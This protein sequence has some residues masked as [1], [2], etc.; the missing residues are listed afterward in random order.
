MSK[1]GQKYEIDGGQNPWLRLA[2]AIIEQAVSDYR[3][4]WETYKRRYRR[5]PRGKDLAEPLEKM[6]VIE[7]FF[8]SKWYGTL[9]DLDGEYLLRLLKEE[10]EDDLQRISG[11]S[12]KSEKDGYQG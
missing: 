8:H 10:M 1:M 3:K 6:K 4:E 12:R 7:K 5:N 11:D 2:N 9:T